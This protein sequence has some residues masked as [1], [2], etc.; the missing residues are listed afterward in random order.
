MEKYEISQD[1][2]DQRQGTGHMGMGKGVGGPEGVCAGGWR[3]GG[4]EGCRDDRDITGGV[5]S[6]GRQAWASGRMEEVV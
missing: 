5:G 2:Y 6:E 1:A 3:W 4:G